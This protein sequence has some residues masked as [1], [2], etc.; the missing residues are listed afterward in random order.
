MPSESNHPAAPVIEPRFDLRQLRH[1]VAVAEELHFGRAAN[2][3][4]MTQPPLSQ[5]ILTLEAAL[6]HALFVRTRRSVQLTPAGEALLPE[7]QR[8]L[9]DAAQLPQLVQ[10]AA[11]GASGQ[12]VLSFVSSAAYGL[13]PPLLQ[14]F[15]A[16]YPGVKIVLR[17]ATSDVQFADLAQGRIDCGIVI[18]PLPAP[19]AS[20]CMRTTVDTTVHTI[21]RSASSTGNPA[22]TGTA[23]ADSVIRAANTGTPARFAWRTLQHEPLVLALPSQLAAQLPERPLPLERCHGQDLIIFPRAI[24]P[25]FHDM[26]LA[27]FTRAGLTPQIAQEAIQMQTIVSLVSANFGIALV[28]KSV[29]NL[30]RTG[31]DYV[32]MA[33]NVPVLE[34]GLA[35]REGDTG[36]VLGAFLSVLENLAIGPDGANRAGFD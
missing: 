22:T 10:R 3:L 5:S 30:Q 8:L 19:S 15:R 1:F 26:I 16:Q 20:A 12:L 36:P 28:P 4:C 34:T 6:G 7:A 33:G 27:C 11:L 18:P 13:L 17:E 21:T 14:A 25:A 32:E 35:W 2:R 24:A 29:S 31:V 9:Q 23:G